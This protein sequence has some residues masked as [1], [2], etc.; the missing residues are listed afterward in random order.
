MQLGARCLFATYRVLD[1]NSRTEKQ[2][3]GYEN[4]T[5]INSRSSVCMCVHASILYSHSEA[6]EIP[7][8]LLYGP[9]LC[10]LIWFLTETEA[11]HLVRLATRDCI[12]LTEMAGHAQL[13]CGTEDLGALPKQVLLTHGAPPPPPH[14]HNK[15]I[16]CV[17]RH[18]ISYNYVFTLNTQLTCNGWLIFT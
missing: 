6:R 11:C 15:F 10:L 14:L 3:E 17:Q 18:R 13:S 2:K 4:M 9:L 7:R 1:S 16:T 5:L 12:G 8:V